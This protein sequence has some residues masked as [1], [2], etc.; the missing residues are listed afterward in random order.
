MWVWSPTSGWEM[1]MEGLHPDPWQKGGGICQPG[2]GMPPGWSMPPGNNRSI[3]V[4]HRWYRHP[5]WQIH[6]Y[7]GSPRTGGIVEGQWGWGHTPPTDEP[8]PTKSVVYV[9][10]FA[11]RQGLC[12]FPEVGYQWWVLDRFQL[13]FLTETG[14]EQFL[15]CELEPIYSGQIYLRRDGTGKA[16]GSPPRCRDSSES[17][18]NHSKS[19]P[20]RAMQVD[21][22]P[23]RSTIF[24]KNDGIPT[25]RYSLDCLSRPGDKTCDKAS[26]RC[27]NGKAWLTYCL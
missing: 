15:V 26:Q 21:S 4:W 10:V 3:L 9:L 27:V 19:L 24:S 2:W 25:R 12:S 6:L 7:G 16:G 5:Q 18:R 11:S 8:Y 17:N 22:W 1:I 20:A 23:F 14:L 13:Q